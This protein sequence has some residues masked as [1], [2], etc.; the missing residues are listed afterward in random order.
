LIRVAFWYDRPIAYSGGL[1]YIRNLLYAI[2]LVNA[3]RIEP[4]LFLGMAVPAKEAEGFES[5]ARVIRTPMLDRGNAWWFIDR[6]LV[7][8]AGS[9]LLVKRELRRCGIQ[10]V[11]HA[12]HV[13]GLGPSCRVISWF[14]DFQFLHLPEFFPGLDVDKEIRRLRAIISKADAIVLSSY[15]AF[16]DFQ[17]I[18]PQSAVP[19]ARVLQFVSQPHVALNSLGEPMAKQELERKYEIKGRYFYLPN[20]FWVHKNHWVVFKAVADLKARGTEIVLL[21]TGNL[22]DYRVRNSDYVDALREFVISESLG[23][24]IRILGLVPYE[25]VLSLM[26]N[27]VA[28]INPSRFEGWSS[29]VEE[30]KSIGKKIALS[31]IAVHQEQRPAGAQYFDPD[32]VSGLCSILEQWWSSSEV[33]NTNAECEAKSSLRERTLRYGEEYIQLVQQVQAG[34]TGR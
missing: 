24:N 19:R 5:L 16:A 9:Q 14:P 4:F 31:N 27:C 6:L 11:S 2:S 17:T 32:D 1:N 28:V 21:C 13:A 22:K 18:A 20:Q 26:R 7:R 33:S 23:A 3:G 10:V 8:C 12:A 30:A 29:T 25:D 34:R 15:A